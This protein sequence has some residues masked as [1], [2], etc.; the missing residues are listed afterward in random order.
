MLGTSQPN[1]QQ[2]LKLK[3][4][5]EKLCKTGVAKIPTGNQHRWTLNWER[6]LELKKGNGYH[7][8]Q[9][10]K[11]TWIQMNNARLF[12][13]R[14][15]KRY[16][17]QCKSLE[18]VVLQL[19]LDCNSHQ[20]QST[21]SVISDDRRCNRTTSGGPLIPQPCIT[22]SIQEGTTGGEGCQTRESHLLL[23]SHFI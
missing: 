10:N 22:R 5:S 21:Q 18:H 23:L 13:K 16:A 4:P 3:S 7:F 11:F 1:L 19:S 15:D 14:V 17:L 6:S 8:K 9:I 2:K 12:M 20:Y